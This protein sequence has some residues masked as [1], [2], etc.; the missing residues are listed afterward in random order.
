MKKLFIDLEICNKCKQCVTKC[1]YFYRTHNNGV[2]SL[3]ELAARSRVCR[4]CEEA[5]CVKAC[6]NEALEKNTEGDLRRYSMRCS[7]CKTCVLACPFGAIYPEIVPYL[8]SQCDYCI[9][10]VGENPPVCVESCPLGAV[11]Y[12]EVKESKEKNIY[13]IS[14]K[15]AVHSISW[16]KE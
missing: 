14:D 10:T 11:K 13:S 6:P 5:P 1:G 8:T 4:K 9:G 7:S 12:I 3:L 15:L 2:I 16:G